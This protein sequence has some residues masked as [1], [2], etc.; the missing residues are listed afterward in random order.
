MNEPMKDTAHLPPPCTGLGYP[1]LP[2]NS[3]DPHSK[4]L[5]NA[6]LLATAQDPSHGGVAL[7]SKADLTTGSHSSPPS[8]PR[9]HPEVILS[10]HSHKAGLEH[11][12]QDFARCGEEA[13]ESHFL[14][15]AG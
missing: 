2:L 12:R 15:H 14:K 8:H 6:T 1:S 11:K 9:A 7:V 10:T 13:R 3:P 5:L 4:L